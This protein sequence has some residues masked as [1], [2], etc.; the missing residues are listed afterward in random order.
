MQSLGS[1]V[2]RRIL[3]IDD[4]PSIHHDYR[5]ILVADPN[6]NEILDDAEAA[7]Y[8]D[9]VATTSVC[10]PAIE[11]DSAF[12]GEE[13]LAKVVAAQTENRPYSLAFVDMRMPPGWSGLRTIEEIWKVNP[14][15]QIVICS[16]YSDNSW[17]DIYQRL[18]Q[19]DRLLV[20][21]KPF[22]NVE[23][24]AGHRAD[25]KME[26]DEAGESETTRLGT[27]GRRT[28]FTISPSR[29]GVAA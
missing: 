19:T 20:L 6:A 25:R 28:Y 11:L 8:G 7:F 10:G 5:K 22:D 3:I 1:A 26:L 9:E 4:S 13:G 14:D 27:A 12:Q 15:L 23:V 24:A 16:A 2:A 29:S 21:K 17:S 18:G